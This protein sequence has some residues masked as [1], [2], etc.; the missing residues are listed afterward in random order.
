MMILRVRAQHRNEHIMSPVDH[1][2]TSSTVGTCAVAM[3]AY[4]VGWACC[5]LSSFGTICQRANV[6]G[7]QPPRERDGHGRPGK[8][9]ATAPDVLHTQPT[10]GAKKE[11]KYPQPSQTMPLCDQLSDNA[12]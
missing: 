12:S 4:V 2:G 3:L 11:D 9:P 6:R 8:D 7:T 1:C 5:E 10:V